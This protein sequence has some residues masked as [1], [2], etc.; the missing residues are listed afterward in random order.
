[1]N[2]D[3]PIEGFELYATVEEIR[4]RDFPDLDADLVAEV[5]TMQR[6]HSEDQ[7]EARSKTEQAISRWV[8]Q[9]LGKEEV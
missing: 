2:N 7:A 1:M 9:H 8:A 5:L 3:Q 6:L 4:Q